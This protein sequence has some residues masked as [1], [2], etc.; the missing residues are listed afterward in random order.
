MVEHIKYQKCYFRY[1]PWV[2]CLKSPACGDLVEELQRSLLSWRIHQVTKSTKSL[3]NCL[4]YR[5]TWVR[6]YKFETPQKSLRAKISKNSGRYLTTYAK[7]R[8]CYLCRQFYLDTATS[9]VVQFL[10]LSSEGH[11]DI[12][13]RS[14]CFCSK[15]KSVEVQSPSTL[16]SMVS[17]WSWFCQQSLVLETEEFHVS[18][19][20]C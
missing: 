2:L 1:K 4:H 20:I 18:F 5:I 15:P 9:W 16:S 14:Q 12:T 13:K 3:I 17:R 8:L 10:S 11:V 19:W 6:I 7:D